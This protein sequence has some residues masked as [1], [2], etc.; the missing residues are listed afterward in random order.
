MVRSSSPLGC[1]WNAGWLTAYRAVRI[2][3]AEIFRE[4]SLIPQGLVDELVETP[5]QV[6]A[7]AAS[8]LLNATTPSRTLGFIG[9]GSVITLRPLIT[10]EMP[11]DARKLGVDWPRERQIDRLDITVLVRLRRPDVGSVIALEQAG[12]VR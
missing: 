9:R 3:P 8:Q 6:V 12:C 10:P 11:E 7:L 2:A 5:G 1:R 4:A